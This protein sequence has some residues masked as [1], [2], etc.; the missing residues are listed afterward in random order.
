MCQTSPSYTVLVRSKL[1]LL[2][3]TLYCIE[4]FKCLQTFLCTV[5]FKRGC[6]S[7]TAA[8]QWVVNYTLC[9]IKVVLHVQKVFTWLLLLIHQRC[10][11]SH[12]C[13]LLTKYLA[14]ASI[15]SLY[16]IRYT[17]SCHV[18]GIDYIEVLYIKEIAFHYHTHSV[19]AVWKVSAWLYL[20]Q[21]K[22][23]VN[24]TCE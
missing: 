4:Y 7:L 17:M 9:S 6:V 18:C 23:C 22:I 21:N 8:Q 2:C 1:K 16:C 10:F 13:I 14:T 19:N 24:P 20:A 12:S 15:V 11:L 3:S 5:L